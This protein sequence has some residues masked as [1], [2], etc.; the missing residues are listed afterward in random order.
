MTPAIQDVAAAFFVAAFRTSVVAAEASPGHAIVGENLEVSSVER[1]ELRAAEMIGCLSLATD[2]GIGVPL[3][4]GLLSTWWRFVLLIVL[5][6]T[7]RRRR[8]CSIAA[9]CS[10]SVARLV[11][12]WQRPCSVPM[13]R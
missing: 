11:L 8:R 3:E 12:S 7:R 10:M 2:L 9:C 6:S 4:H 5:V 1:E 13:T